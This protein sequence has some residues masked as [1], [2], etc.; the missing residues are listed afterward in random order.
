MAIWKSAKNTNFFQVAVKVQKI[1]VISC[2]FT[3]KS[4]N[5]VSNSTY[6]EFYFKRLKNEFVINILLWFVYFLLQPVFIC[7]GIT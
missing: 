5:T 6:K 2:K 4:L 1:N 7:F 3:E